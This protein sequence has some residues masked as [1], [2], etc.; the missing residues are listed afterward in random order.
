[1]LYYH[2]CKSCN[3]EWEESYSIKED[4]PKICPQCKVEGLVQRLITGAPA[5]KMIL[6]A[7]EFKQSLKES[8]HKIQKEIGKNENFK[9]NL[10]GEDKYQ[11]F[12]SENDRIKTKYGKEMD[13]IEKKLSSD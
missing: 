13:K 11:S 6:S 3:H 7:S 12:K 10:A 2:L 8:K 5:V 4:P 9:A 1:M